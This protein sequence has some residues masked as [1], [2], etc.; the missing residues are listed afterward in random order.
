MNASVVETLVEK[1]PTVSEPWPGLAQAPGLLLLRRLIKQTAPGRA[2]EVTDSERRLIDETLGWIEKSLMPAK[3]DVI[4]RLI[5]AV[6]WHYPPIQR[7]EKAAHSVAKDWLRDL[8]HLPEDLLDA[9]CCHWRR[10]Q[11]SF[12]PSPGHLLTIANPIWQHRHHLFEM[13]RRLFPP[14]GSALDMRN[15][16]PMGSVKAASGGR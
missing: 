13:G 11:N 2:P 3:P 7:P 14:A 6:M 15:A 9:A 1:L 10:G 16:P 12:A 4:G 5:E 8:G